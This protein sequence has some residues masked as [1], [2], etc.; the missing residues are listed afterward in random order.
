M[1]CRDARELLDSFIGEELLVETN[2]ELLRHLASCPE[3]SA[4]LEGR[5]RIRAGLKQA[6]SRSADLQVRPE[7]ANELTTRLRAPAQPAASQASWVRWFAIAASL[8]AVVG[9][10]TYVLRTRISEVT[11]LA[12]G[13]H[14]N[15]AVKFA[16]QEKPISLEEASERYD[17]AYA[18]LVATPPDTV[19]T[20]AGILRIADRHS[21]V[22][23]GRRFGHVVFRLDDHPV[24]VLMTRDDLT[25]V[26][27][28]DD[29]RQLSW[30]PRT[31]GLAMASLRTTGHVVYI[32]SD[33]QDSD[34]RAVA[35]AL[36]LPVSQLA[37]V[38]MS[39]EF[40]N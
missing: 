4:E 35:Q 9:A 23:G 19:R 6:F 13:D 7:F 16:L 24:S 3:C 2:H 21:C 5:G 36:V 34:F 38:G 15:C 39:R 20:P 10:G 14:Q 29:V 1:E 33:L 22:F 30:L 26:S 40:G 31:N 8:L 18:Q 32:V 25:N 17:A 12:A 11:R 28:A 37:A 27:S